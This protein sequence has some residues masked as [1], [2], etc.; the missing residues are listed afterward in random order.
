MKVNRHVAFSAKK[1]FELQNYIKTNQISFEEDNMTFSFDICE[2]S[3]FWIFIK[4]YIE[5][6]NIF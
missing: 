6:E 1:H 3:S 5:R 2:D 4:E